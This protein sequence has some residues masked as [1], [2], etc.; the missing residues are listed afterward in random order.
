MSGILYSRIPEIDKKENQKLANHKSALKRARQNTVRQARN[1][2]SKSRI[3][4]N[5][6]KVM[7]AIEDNAHDSAKAA[8]KTA[9]SIID[10]A[11]KKGVIHKRAASRKISHLARR[12][13]Q[14]ASA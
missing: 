11:S 1:K 4:N 2:E 6:K 3:K 13:N 8:L 9:Q 14:L 10:K 5:I 7:T 12:I